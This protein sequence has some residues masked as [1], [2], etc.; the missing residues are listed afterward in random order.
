M[1]RDVRA[2]QPQQMLFVEHDHVIEHLATAA[3]DPGLGDTVLPR[4]A[5]RRA[6]WVHAHAAQ[7]RGDGGAENRV[8]VEEEVRGGGVVQK[9]LAQ[10][11]FHP[12]RARVRGDR[13]VRHPAPAMA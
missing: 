9:S 7:G 12:R 5:I 4:T 2:Q 8:V 11:L 3:A 1:V 13:D 10:L 6:D